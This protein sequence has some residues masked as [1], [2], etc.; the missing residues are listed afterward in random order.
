MGACAGPEMGA[1]PGPKMGAFTGP[2]MG[3]C[4]GNKESITHG[5]S[6]HNGNQGYKNKTGTKPV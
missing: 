3:A 1:C 6:D 2:K 5:L 4:A